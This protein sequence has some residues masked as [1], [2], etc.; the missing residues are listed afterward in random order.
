MLIVASYDI[1]YEDI[2]IPFYTLNRKDFFRGY[3][4]SKDIDMNEILRFGE[5]LFKG[6]PK[7]TIDFSNANFQ[8]LI[9]ENDEIYTEYIKNIPLEYKGYCIEGFL[10]DNK[11]LDK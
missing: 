11:S 6:E 1:P 5:A 10:D 9:R 7:S 3:N 2:R 4:Q 8:I